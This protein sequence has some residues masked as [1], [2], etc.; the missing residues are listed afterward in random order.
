MTQPS[1]VLIQQPS[2]DFN[3]FLGVSHKLLGRS[4]AASVD[5]SSRKL[6]DTEKFLACLNSFDKPAS[7]VT[8]PPHLLKHVTFSVLVGADERDLIDIVEY[9]A[10]PFVKAETSVRGVMLAV[11]TGTLDKWRDAVRAG[12]SPDADYNIRTC[13]CR[14]MTLFE[15]AGLGQVWS[16]FSKR[17]SKNDTLFYLEDKR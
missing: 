10:M 16:G 17:H 8:L 5:A 12:T 3:T 15:M 6:T 2:I 11:I 1:V 9:A 4:P 13:Y 7:T 14:I